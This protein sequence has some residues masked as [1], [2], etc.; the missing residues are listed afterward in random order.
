MGEY[1]Y[2]IDTKFRKATDGRELRKY[3]FRNKVDYKYPSTAYP[4]RF[5]M[6]DE[7]LICEGYH[8]GSAVY[9][10]WHG[11]SYVSDYS[12]RWEKKVLVGWLKKSKTNRLTI[13]SE[14]EPDAKL[15]IM[16]DDHNEHKGHGFKI[17]PDGKIFY[18]QFINDVPF[19]DW[20]ELYEGHG[21]YFYW[22]RY[23]ERA[24]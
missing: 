6:L 15:V 1:I 19:Y 18:N 7:C 9:K 4:S 2:S 22:T 24:A 10:M 23:T 17:M 5:T 3:S 12:N 14:I 20:E 11:P 21:Y 16:K 13:V 8:T